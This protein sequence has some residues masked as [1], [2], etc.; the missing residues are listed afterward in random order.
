MRFLRGHGHRHGRGP[1]GA[2][3]VVA[4]AVVVLPGM[5]VADAATGRSGSPKPSA[6]G[7][8]SP[9]PSVSVR[10]AAPC[11]VLAAAVYQ[12]GQVAASTCQGITSVQTGTGGYEVTFPGPARD[13]VPVAS[14]GSDGLAAWTPPGEIAADRVPGRPMVFQ[15]RTFSDVGAPASRAFDIALSC[16]R[17]SRDSGVVTIRSPSRSAWVAVPCGIGRRAV[18]LATAQAGSGPAV[19]WAAPDRAKCGVGIHLSR[20]PRRGH[21]VAVAWELRR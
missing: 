2:V 6:A 18:V 11:Q 1:A 10:P 5:A 13:C 17:P 15:V 8:E 21:T 4:V 19:S 9:K 12:A 14:L 7:S 3:A 20:A 16:A